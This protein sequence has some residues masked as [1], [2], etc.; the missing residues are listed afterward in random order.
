MYVIAQNENTKTKPKT[1]SDVKTNF[2]EK[3]TTKLCVICERK[4]TY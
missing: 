1:E 4:A 3:Q 2:Q